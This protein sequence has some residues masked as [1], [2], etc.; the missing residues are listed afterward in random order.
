MSVEMKQ[1]ISS[2]IKYGSIFGISIFIIML[3]IG[4]DKLAIIF[5]L[6]LAIAILNFIL[7]GII[8]EKSI[9]SKSKLMQIIFPLSYIARISIIVIVALPF[10][11][12]LKMISTYMIGFITYFPILILSWNLSKG[13]SK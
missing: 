13:G 2:I 3:I 10:I 1:M 12:D 7:N 4:E 8:L 11:Y 6:G 9:S 5:S